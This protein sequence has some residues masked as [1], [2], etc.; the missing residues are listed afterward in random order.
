MEAIK[1]ALVDPKT[2]IVADL[3]RSSSS[4]KIERILVVGCGSG[5]EAAVLAQF[6][7]ADVIGIDIESNFDSTAQQFADLR[8]GDATALEFADE[9]FDLVYS[10][11][12][13]EHIPDCRKALGEMARVVKEDGI[14]CVGTPNR[15]RAVGY[16]GSKS[17]TLSQ[18]VAWNI[19]D[20]KARA[21]G[22]FKN[23]FGAH[24]GFTAVELSGLLAEHFE[25][26][27]NITRQ[28]YRALYR[29]HANTIEFFFNA[30]VASLVLPAVYFVAYRRQP[31]NNASRQL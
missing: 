30:R 19:T 27:D 8:Q 23:E 16:L 20:W 18:K 11:H 2:A 15:S 29:R 28:Y 6:F 10:Y 7:D 24:A 25:H 31:L 14:V 9:S 5:L 26:V 12:A 22:K 3:V 17:A 4:R 1:P 13:L 21:R